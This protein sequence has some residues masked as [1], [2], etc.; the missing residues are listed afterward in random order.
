[1]QIIRDALGR[2][3]GVTKVEG[4]PT[5]KQIAVTVQRG[6]LPR[7]QIVGEIAKLGHTID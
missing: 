3:P 1:V 7:D 6:S 2:F 5:Q 4:E